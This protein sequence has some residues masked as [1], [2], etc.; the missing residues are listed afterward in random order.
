MI[1]YGK[2]ASLYALKKHKSLIKKVYV[3]KLSILPK[4]LLR[5]FGSKVKL[6]ENRWAQKM[7][8]N[9]N[10]QGILVDI[11]EPQEPTIEAIKSSNFIVLL[12]GLTD[13]GNIG[14][15]IRTSY[16][17]GVD[18][19]VASGVNQIN[20]SGIIRSSS[21][22]AL[23]L[24]P[25]V[26]KNPLSLLN[27]LKQIGFK[28]FGASMDGEPLGGANFATKRVLILGSE[29]R[30]ISKRVESKIDRFYAIEMQRDFDS[31]NVSVAAGIL[32]YR[33]GHAVK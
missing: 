5:E 13:V 29:D 33:M 27:E 10:H 17:L 15:I 25:L 26:L 1:I 21:G 20:L 7:S 28:I 32:I 4:D 6:I 11:N 22:A 14:A 9:R 24:V 23:D 2:Q 12:D 30:G 3:T 19:V 16:A 18:A 8:S 31:L